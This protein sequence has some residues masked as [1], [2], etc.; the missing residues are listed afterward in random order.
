MN[1]FEYDAA[2]GICTLCGVDEAGRGPLAGDVY[3]AAVI[4]PPDANLPG[5]DDSKKL[6]SKKREELF[7]LITEQAV[8]FCIAAATAEEIDEYN[9]LQATFLAMTRAVNGLSSAPELVLIDGNRR[10]ANLKGLCECVV[11]GDATSA[12]IAAASV[13]AKVAR[14]RYMDA[15]AGE[16]P[17]YGFEKHK[18]YPTKEHYAA[19]LKYGPCPV[20]R[21]TFLKN[22]SDGSMPNAHMIGAAGEAAAADYLEKNGFTILS[23]NYH[24]TYGEIDL[25]AENGE[26]LVFAEVKTRKPDSL[27]S[28][29]EA[30]TL[31][32]QKKIIKTA[33]CYLSDC[34]ISLQPRFDVIEVLTEPDGLAV[35]QV[36][37]AFLIP[38][39]EFS[40]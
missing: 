38:A 15:L 31:A 30:V 33:F 14:D 37:N 32:K 23:R 36:E 5:L 28:P 19:I 3:A 18:G 17:A 11:K 39:G 40:F 16:Y 25:I 10:P 34:G 7:E 9:I 12:S 35:R 6:T 27:V 1:L 4:L 20:H 21:K 2:R 26:Y 13:L 29:L 22:L 8:S 24:S